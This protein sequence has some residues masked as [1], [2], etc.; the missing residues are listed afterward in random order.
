MT[1]TLV[2][3]TADLRQAL[4]AVRPHASTDK[5]DPEISRIRLTIGGEN[6]VVTATDRFTAGLAIASTWDHDGE[7]GEIVEVLADDAAKILA[8][9][10]SGKEAGD[11][12]PQYLL[13]LDID[14][15][16][17]TVTDCSGMI[18][19]R[20]FRMPRLATEDS[21]N[22]VPVLID[23]AHGGRTVLLDD[24]EN[25]TVSG[26][27]LGRFKIAATTYKEALSLETRAGSAKGSVCVL[28]RCGESFLG[29]MMPR[30]LLG[31]DRDRAR[32]WADGWTARLP[33]IVGA[34][35]RS[36]DS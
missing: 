7:P 15:E 34:A 14:D 17:V 27:H 12:S 11:D 18:D 22:V 20:R 31:E 5:D 13:R 2:V 33:E 3:G 21:L 6:I 26:D 25:M 36:G 24:V 30:R 32:D 1:T 8:I 16:H 23:R 9:F 35:A 29:L 10:K 19:G 28:I 4:T